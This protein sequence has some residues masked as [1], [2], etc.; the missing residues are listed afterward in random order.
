MPATGEVFAVL[1]IE[2]SERG[3]EGRMELCQSPHELEGCR[4]VEMKNGEGFEAS[5]ELHALFAHVHEVQ[6]ELLQWAA[7]DAAFGLTEGSQEIVC[8][9]AALGNHE[10]LGSRDGKYSLQPRIL[11][12]FIQP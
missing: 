2:P 9:E 1:D 10:A 11:L 7:L 4:H 6:V 12:L 5:E 3:R 8:I